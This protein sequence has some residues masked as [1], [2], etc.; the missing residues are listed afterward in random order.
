MSPS[1][2]MVYRY[3]MYC[4]SKNVSFN[5]SRDF[6]TNTDWLLQLHG[7]IGRFH[8]FITP[9]H[10]SSSTFLTENASTKSKCKE[11]TDLQILYENRLKHPRNPVI[12]F[13]DINSFR[14]KIVDAREVFRKLQL[15]Y[16]VLSETKFGDTFA[17]AQFWIENFETRN[18]RDRDKNGSG[19]IEF[20]KNEFITRKIKENETKVSKTIAS[21]FAILMKKW[22]CLGVYRPPTSTNLDIFF[23]KLT[24]SLGCQ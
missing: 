13:L 22:F 18:W 14:N 17:S 2:S 15:D 10:T 9:T 24:N 11:C 5:L 1:T 12:G 4:Y 16:F 20:A 23:E 21:E 19:L 7:S 8:W 6:L 3:L